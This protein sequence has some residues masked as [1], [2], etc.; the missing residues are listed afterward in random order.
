MTIMSVIKFLILLYLFEKNASGSTLGIG[1]K[2]IRNKRILILEEQQG[3]FSYQE[4]PG[5]VI[6]EHLNEWPRDKDVRSQ[7]NID[8]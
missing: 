5:R 8:Q 6:F 2:A 1:I 3:G 4:W 7:F